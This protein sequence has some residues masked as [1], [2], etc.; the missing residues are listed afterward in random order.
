MN[1]D[2]L[3]EQE[4]NKLNIIYRE[5]ELG[6]T[7]AVRD[8]LDNDLGYNV[9]FDE[10]QKRI[11]NMLH[12]GNYK[13]YV[14]CDNEIAIGFVAAVS[15]LAFEVKNPVMKVI[16]FAVSEK[17]RN[18]G[19]GTNLL[20]CIETFAQDNHIDAILLNSG[21]PREAAHKFY[22]AQG[23]RKKSFGFVKFFH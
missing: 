15:Y 6:D 20:K 23:Y 12:H 10:L 11:R 8:I 5:F 17:F 3:P 2:K 9:A 18:N 7:K 1:N 4:M 21:L 22:E 14:A 19:I 13:I 16:A